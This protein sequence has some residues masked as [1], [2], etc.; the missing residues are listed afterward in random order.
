LS[1]GHGAYD[2]YGKLQKQYAKVPSKIDCWTDAN[3]SSLNKVRS[4][5]KIAL[6]LNSPKPYIP[7]DKEKLIKN[8]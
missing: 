5:E 8:E 4:K 6:N 1:L 7:Y 2:Y 3:S